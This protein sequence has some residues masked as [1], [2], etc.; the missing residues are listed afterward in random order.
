MASGPIDRLDETPRPHD[1]EV[2]DNI[3]THRH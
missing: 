1:F 3:Y 2:V